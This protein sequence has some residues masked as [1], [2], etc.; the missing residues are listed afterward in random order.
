MS[1]YVADT[2]RI[3]ALVE[4]AKRIGGQIE[5]RIADVE[6]EVGAMHID[7]EG[8]AADAHRTNHETWTRE[9][10]DMR[11]ALASLEAAAK[12]AHDR[13][14]ANVEHNMGMWP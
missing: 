9:T 6:R 8:V 5:Q 4:Q 11:R 3:L 10:G 2:D 14:V 1:R 13:Y 12:G 7:W